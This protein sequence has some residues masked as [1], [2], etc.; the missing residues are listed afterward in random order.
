MIICANLREQFMASEKKPSIYYDRGTIGSSKELDEYGVWVKSEPQDLSPAST[1]AFAELS[2]ESES[3]LP[4]LINL[5][6]LDTGIENEGLSE[7]FSI[8]DDFS[9]E[10]STETDNGAGEGVDE[11][12][13]GDLDAGAGEGIDEASLGDLGDDGTGKGIDE[14]SFEDLGG[15][16]NSLEIEEDFP[17]ESSDFGDESLNVSD[18]AE[19]STVSE[20]G[21]T[22]ISMEDFLG[23]TS[24]TPPAPD[25]VEKTTVEINRER[26]LPHESGDSDSP[27]AGES[28]VKPQKPSA[29]ELS[30][31]LLI[32]IADELVSIR[33][34][35]STLKSE[36]SA[37]HPSNVDGE[38]GEAQGHGFF[39]EE[40]DEK[41]A[42][43]GDELDNILNTADF[44]EESGADAGADTIEEVSS[45]PIDEPP[46]E[47]TL[48]DL[49][50]AD[51]TT[52]DESPVDETLS[53]L[54]L[55][56]I[57][58]DSPEDFS[59]L[60]ITAGDITEETELVFPP[61]D[62]SYLEEDPLAPLPPLPEF[63]F[64]EED[65]APDISFETSPELQSGARDGS[66]D[67]YLEEVVF[68]ENVLDFSNAVIDEPDLGADITENP[69]EEPSLDEII[70]DDPGDELSLIELEE[71][72][73]IDLDLEESAESSA[74]E[75]LD[76]DTDSAFGQVEKELEFSIPEDTLPEYLPEPELPVELPAASEALPPE[77]ESFAQVI[78]EGFVVEE[79]NAPIAEDDTEGPD[80]AFEIS[81]DDGIEEAVGESLLPEES[82]G[83]QIPEEEAPVE[84][85]EVAGESFEEVTNGIPE[86]SDAASIG[87]ISG[88]F[89]QELKTVLSYMDQLLE[90]LPENKIEEFAKSEY[91]DTYKKLFKELGI[92]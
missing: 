28:P 69:V 83:R 3:S 42:L 88:N 67:S 52:F 74:E 33:N 25:A 38:H 54:T 78:P 60:E 30:T 22:E 91:F 40:E 46:A 49:T 45:P 68:D 47:L 81:L 71:P 41:I 50:P 21:F 43:T 73:S 51:E 59:T 86:T 85:K 17:D 8:D 13:F 35:L 44:T 87:D 14:A 37:I 11:V 70:L 23:D 58:A 7:D 89:R 77:E 34:E 64:G 18:S 15:G 57:P 92:V 55:D 39:D 16:E 76:G 63:A 12:S 48:G 75:S 19:D 20:D 10:D 31:Q 72:V 90:S 36:F 4:D 66:E 2:T 32:K 26:E 65:T 27:S 62:T 6:D 56:D 53:D 82:S 61:D 1:A 80:D 84:L 5:P 9:I 79:E 24:N 29:S